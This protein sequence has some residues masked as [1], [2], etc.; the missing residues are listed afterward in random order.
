[1][2]NQELL[3]EVEK[4][5]NQLD[6]SS[7]GIKSNLREVPDTLHVKGKLLSPDEPW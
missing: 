1:M 7:K 5:N 4:L 3:S 6:I 2:R